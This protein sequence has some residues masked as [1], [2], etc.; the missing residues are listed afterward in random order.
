MAVIIIFELINIK[1]AQVLFNQNYNI[2]I[3]KNIRHAKRETIEPV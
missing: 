2:S 1:R 3:S